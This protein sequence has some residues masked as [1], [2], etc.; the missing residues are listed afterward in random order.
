MTL[1][2]LIMV[3]GSRRCRFVT[4][5]STAFRTSKLKCL[6]NATNSHS[7]TFVENQQQPKNHDQNPTTRTAFETAPVP[8]MHNHA[9]L[10]LPMTKTLHNGPSTALLQLLQQRRSLV[11]GRRLHQTKCVVFLLH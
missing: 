11:R 8:Q 9:P 5:V 10:A 3:S 1:S 6:S 2:P 4:V 7:T